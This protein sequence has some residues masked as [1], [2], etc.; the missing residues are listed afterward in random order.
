MCL[1]SFDFFLIFESSTL[2]DQK[3]KFNAANVGSTCSGFNDILPHKS[4]AALQAAVAAVGPISVAIDA[5]HTS[6][7]VSRG[8][9]ESDWEGEP[10]GITF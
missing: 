1:E 7:Q 6:F 9:E 2:Q 3:C 8:G 10:R 4:E 5:S